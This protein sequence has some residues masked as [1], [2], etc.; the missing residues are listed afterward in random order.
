MDTKQVKALAEVEESARDGA[1]SLRSMQIEEPDALPSLTKAGPSIALVLSDR[2]NS[3]LADKARESVQASERVETDM[4]GIERGL[5]DVRLMSPCKVSKGMDVEMDVEAAPVTETASMQVD[6]L[7]GIEFS[8]SNKLMDITEDRSD[9]KSA[10]PSSLRTEYIVPLKDTLPTK[11][12]SGKSTWNDVQTPVSFSPG[13]VAFAAL[14]SRGKSIG[15]AKRSTISAKAGGD[16]DAGMSTEGRNLVGSSARSV[17]G[18]SASAPLVQPVSSVGPGSSRSQ[19]APVSQSASAN[20]TTTNAANSQPKS[21]GGAGVRSSWLR[22]AMA[23]AGGEQGVRKSM[24]GNVLRKKSEFENGDV[25]EEEEEV[26]ETERLV[27]EQKPDGPIVIETKSEKAEEEVLQIRLAKEIKP[28]ERQPLEPILHSKVPN[29]NTIPLSIALDLP[30]AAESMPQSKLAKMIADLEEKKAAASASRMTMGAGATSAHNGILSGWNPLRSTLGGLFLR[31]EVGMSKGEPVPEVTKKTDEAGQE[32]DEAAEADEQ[33]GFSKRTVT[34]S[35]REETTEP[36]QPTANAVMVEVET[37]LAIDAEPAIQPVHEVLVIAEAS[38]TDFEMVEEHPASTTPTDPV[39]PEPPKTAHGPIVE[40]SGRKQSHEMYIE[41]VLRSPVRQGSRSDFTTPI[42][43][44]PQIFESTT[45]MISPPRFIKA[46]HEAQ[47][48]RAPSQLQ[49]ISVAPPNARQPK[50]S[51]VRANSAEEIQSKQDLGSSRPNPFSALP[52]RPKTSVEPVQPSI[53]R[54]PIESASSTT[55]EK[56]EGTRSKNASPVPKTVRSGL[57]ISTAMVIPDE[58]SSGEESSD[59]SEEGEDEEEEDEREEAD[60]S[61]EDIEEAVALLTKD[62]RL[63]DEEDHLQSR[64]TSEAPSE[65][66]DATDKGKVR[67]CRYRGFFGLFTYDYLF[68]IAHCK[69]FTGFIETWSLNHL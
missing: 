11:T 26:I 20:K 60:E 12:P 48:I 54:E 23:N 57:S 28:V 14:P 58:E 44:N 59:D 35:S 66:E 4:D 24:A 51:M 13:S 16:V 8:S 6:E 2:A 42:K 56:I 61:K 64:A 41:P 38:T 22:Q 1:E 49:H 9:P 30:Q 3:R 25:E 43:Q 17:E 69:F 31:E 32:E 46:A 68:C 27:E 63:D 15:G 10:A 45:P 21:G 29:T 52:T 37:E 40:G 53:Q 65:T 62:M 5:E 67:D 36:V 7:K 19:Q 33:E 50:L 18:G 34:V 55:T 47:P 39:F